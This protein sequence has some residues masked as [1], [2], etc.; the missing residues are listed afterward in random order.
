MQNVVDF[1]REFFKSR[2]NEEKREMTSR[3]PFRETFFS[4][5]CQYDRRSRTLEILESEEIV[6]LD[7]TDSNAFVI[8]VSKSP[9][10]KI[11]GPTHRKRYNLKLA[12]DSWLI[13]AVQI[14]C[15]V[16]HGLG[17]ANCISCK[18]KHWRGE[19]GAE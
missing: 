12:G 8:T 9:F 10:F 13:Q 17:D 2:V 14:E 7:G 11:G 6:S 3:A 15:P 19:C 4:S 5:D 1:M 16:C 18:G